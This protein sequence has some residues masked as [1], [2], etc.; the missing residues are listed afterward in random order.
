MRISFSLLFLISL[1]FS[2]CYN[3]DGEINTP[4]IIRMDPSKGKCFDLDSLFSE[5][6]LVP[7]ETLSGC[8][9][10]GVRSIKMLDDRIL[11]HANSSSDQ[12]LLFFDS[13]GRFLTKTTKGKGPGEVKIVQSF[14]TDT[15]DQSVWLANNK[16]LQ[17]YDRDG[18]FLGSENSPVSNILSMIRLRKAFYMVTLMGTTCCV[19]NDSIIWQ[20]DCPKSDKIAGVMSV[21]NLLKDQDNPLLFSSDFRTLYK[22]FPDSILPKIIIDFGSS[23]LPIDGPVQNMLDQATQELIASKGYI[24][25]IFNFQLL[26]GGFAFTG[27]WRNRRLTFIHLSESGVT[28]VVSGLNFGLIENTFPGFSTYQDK[29]VCYLFPYVLA[30]LFQD[31]KN[32]TGVQEQITARQRYPAVFQMLDTLDINANPVLLIGKLRG[33]KMESI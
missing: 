20:I 18:S 1:S 14:F 8:L 5:Y 30:R 7:L 33:F 2:S 31:F 19:A 26:D 15:E 16:S 10:G 22:L 23:N 28:R 27:G 3:R 24:S 4:L 21:P 11:V 12:E 13:S 6:R 32:R 25:G 17:H 29:L 9:V